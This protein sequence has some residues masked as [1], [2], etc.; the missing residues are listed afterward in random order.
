MLWK[1]LEITVDILLLYMDIRVL[2]CQIRNILFYLQLHKYG[3]VPP[4]SYKN[5]YLLDQSE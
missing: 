3:E 5:M 4:R 1:S 2:L